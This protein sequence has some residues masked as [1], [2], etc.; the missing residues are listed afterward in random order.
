MTQSSAAAAVCGLR[1][2]ISAFAFTLIAVRYVQPPPGHASFHGTACH[3]TIRLTRHELRAF[4]AETENISVSE[5]VNHGALWLFA[6]LRH[7]C[8]LTCLLTFVL[9]VAVTVLGMRCC[10]KMCMATSRTQDI[11]TLPHKPVFRRSS[12]FIL[13]TWTVPPSTYRHFCSALSWLLRR[14]IR[15]LEIPDPLRRRWLTDA[16]VVLLRSPCTGSQLGRQAGHGTSS[17]SDADVRSGADWPGK[18]GSGRYGRRRL[19]HRV[20]DDAGR[21]G[22]R[23]YGNRTRRGPVNSRIAGSEKGRRLERFPIV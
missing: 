12:R 21:L 13:V 17:R 16:G 20:R 1:R 11:A 4:P 7:R 10:G 9:F 2:Y 8:T 3:H 14:K 15:A 6:I 23:C 5:L 22:N 19:K 18:R